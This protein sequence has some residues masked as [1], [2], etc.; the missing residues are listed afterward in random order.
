MTRKQL[1]AII[2]LY[3]SLVVYFGMY[4]LFWVYIGVGDSW[5]FRKAY[6]FFTR[7]LISGFTG[8]LSVLMF[9][10]IIW[11]PDVLKRMEYEDE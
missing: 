9:N 3:G 10:L 6:S 4:S 11:K 2:S 1:K 5:G 7:G 8:I